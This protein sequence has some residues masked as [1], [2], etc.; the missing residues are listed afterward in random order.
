[1]QMNDEKKTFDDINTPEAEIDYENIVEED[2]REDS[3]SEEEVSEE[4][5][6]ATNMIQNAGLGPINTDSNREFRRKRR[7][8]NQISAYA[9][10]IFFVLIMATVVV[11]GVNKIKSVNNQVAEQ[12]QQVQQEQQDLLDEMLGEEEEIDTPVE[13][14]EPVIELTDAQKLDQIVDAGIEVMPI[15]DKVAGLFIVTPEAIT[16][17]STAVKAGDGTKTALAEYSVGGIIYFSKNI[18]SKDQLAEMIDNTKLYS[19]YPLFIAVD[20][21][22]GNVSRVAKAG[23]ADVSSSPKALGDLGDPNGAYTTGTYIGSYLHELGFNLDFAPV[24]DLSV[25]ESN[26]LGERSYGSDAT[27]V[28]EFVNNMMLGLEEQKVTSCVKH[29]PGVGSSEQDTET[30]MAIS[31][32]TAEE[33]RTEEFPIFQAAID[34]GANMIMMSHMSVPALTGDN[35]PCSLSEAVVTDIL[36]EELG[37]DGVIIADALDMG[38]IK[39]YYASDEAAIMALRAGCDMILM[40]ENFEQAY[41]GVL[42]AVQNG[43]I[44]EERIND[45]LRRIYRIKYAD[46][47]E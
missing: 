32:R 9:S 44:S 41:K 34:A 23:I 47:I 17:V 10:L 1:M 29:F 45:S 16:G 22:G 36:R 42:E 31:D 21:E 15:E 4:Q 38:A 7:V 26:P 11:Y 5:D 24:A 12:Q 43:T 20:E 13:E 28:S 3:I 18:Q 8:R 27:K 40:P 25:A 46:K 19:K 35:T 37:F 30:G 6:E 14:E 2:I 39:E 33:F